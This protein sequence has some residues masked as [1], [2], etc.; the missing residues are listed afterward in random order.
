[1]TEMYQVRY[2]PAALE[3][4][5]S[6]YSYIALTLKAKQTAAKQVNRIRQTIR[7]FD[8]FPE[9][10]AQVDWEPWASLGMRK[11]TVDHYVVFYQVSRDKKEVTVVRIFYGGRD[12]Q[13]IIDSV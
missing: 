2:A 4:L 8:T 9:R 3:D 1:M 6:I 13:H 7:T 5:K 12:I 11:A 10:Y